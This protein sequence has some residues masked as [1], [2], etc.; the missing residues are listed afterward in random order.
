LDLAGT[1]ATVDALHTQRATA[2]HLVSATSADYIMTIKANQ[3]GLL[4]T[5][6]HAPSGPAAEFTEYTEQ[7]RGHG[8]TEERIVRTT[9]VSTAMPIEFPHAAQSF[10]VIRYVGDLT[11]QRHSKEIA[12]CL[13]SLTPDKT[14][15]EDLTTLLREHWG[16]IGNTLHWVR[17]TT[18]HENISTL[19]AGTTPQAMAIRS[20][21][22]TAFRLVSW[23]NLKQARRYFSHTIH[24]CVNLITKPIKTVKYQT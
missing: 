13:T 3:P 10:R 7:S 1:V 17:D 8:R 11:G 16:A 4:A 21:L 24:R 2:E 6:Q 18:F 5:A 9:P 19:R 20:T 15:A 12:H 14:T 22:I 23:R